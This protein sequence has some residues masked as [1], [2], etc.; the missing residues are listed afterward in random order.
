MILS[1]DNITKSFGARDLFREARLRLS[2]RDRLALVGPN[3]AGKTTLLDII[4]GRQ[5]ADSGSVTFAKGAVVGYLEQEAIEMGDHTVLQEAMS[6]AE[7][8]TSLEH[9]L[10]LLEEDLAAT[11]PGEEQERLLSEYGRL[12]ERFEVLGGYTV[13]S[14]ARAV[15]FGLGFKEKDLER[16]TAEFS[17]GWQMRLALAKLLL[18]QP[19]LLLLDEPT[20]HLDLESVTWLEGF[21][22]SYDGA[23]IL[24]S[25]DRAFMEG[26]VDHVAEIDRGRITLY[27]G[28]YSQFE[29]AR[30]LALE[31]LKIAYEA[32]QKEI[33]HLE[34][35]VE[36][37]HAKATKAK[38][39]Q[40]RQRK[41]DKI[42]RIVLP[43]ERKT[44]KFRFPQPVR[45]GDLVL[46]LTGVSKAYG[47]NVVYRNF[48]FSLWRGEKIALVGPNGAG[49]STLL[50]M[51]AGVLTPDSGERVLGHHV[52]VAYFAQHQLQ[53]LNL[54]KTVFQELDGVAPSWTQSEVR[55]LLGAFLFHGND[56]DK[57]V[58]VLSGGEKGRLA[59]AKMLVKPAPLLCL[60]EPT[61]HLDITSADVLEQALRR[62]E[63]TIVLITHDRHLIRSVATKIVEVREGTVTPFS[64]DYDYYLGKVAEREAA[65]KG[66]ADGRGKPAPSISAA[67]PLVVSAPLTADG[68][69]PRRSHGPSG[70][71]APAAAQPVASGPKTKEQKRAE[72]EARNRAHRATRDAKTRL[73]SC[74]KRLHAAQARHDELVARMA[75]PEFYANTS[76]FEAAMAEYAELKASLPRLE[77]EWLELSEDVARA[78]EDASRDQR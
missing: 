23:I 70:T 24:V 68:R 49:K 41:L 44:V 33:A 51:L 52:E 29:A 6:A 12:H 38:Q 8:V 62:Y 64:G 31:Q 5:D 35:F 9:R 67:R 77:E 2:S 45:T 61:N 36:R 13:E 20:N 4:A 25:H 7:H 10:R 57:K 16:M 60:D 74:E 18:R 11:E 15:L 73:E 54:D 48:D 59:L 32:Q 58:R 72:A 40:D 1:V 17:G 69:S 47:D 50:K 14:S 28:N 26:L 21:L 34:A 39:A 55:G 63:G 37:F 3:G 46:R 30:K 75:E 22:R 78:T 43:E 76:E 65:E 27:K 19:D 66:A 53:A 56:V 42:E 71:R